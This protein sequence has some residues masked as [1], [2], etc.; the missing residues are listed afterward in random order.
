MATGIS[1]TLANAWLDALGNAT[2]FSVA[3]PYIK[4]HVGDPGANGTAN[5]ATETT[6]K[7]ASTGVA[8]RMEPVERVPS[9]PAAPAAPSVILPIVE[10]VVVSLDAFVFHDARPFV[11]VVFVVRA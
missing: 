4:L 2:S 10:D 6:R 11:V 5:P 1:S 8:D 9:R 3:T 7:G